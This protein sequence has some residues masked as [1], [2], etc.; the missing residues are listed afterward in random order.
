MTIRT[1][2]S[3]VVRAL[4]IAA[5][6]QIRSVRRSLSR[7]ALLIDRGSCSDCQHGEPLQFGSRWYLC[8][9]ARWFQSVLNAATSLVFSARPSVSHICVLDYRGFHG[10]APSESL[11]WTSD[12]DTRRRLRSADS[13]MLVV[14]STRR[15]TLGDHAFPVASAS[16]RYAQSLTTFRRELKT[17][18][19]RSWFNN[20]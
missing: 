5:L 8:P 14:P 19:F 9:A 7:H 10:T 16:V 1:H 11:L 17:V 20:D 2:D 18:V 15:S 6:R 4:S 13:A 12:V 3:A